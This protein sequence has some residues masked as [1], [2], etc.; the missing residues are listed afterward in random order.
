MGK[1]RTTLGTQL[2]IVL[3]I[4]LVMVVISALYMLLS[5]AVMQEDLL[6]V[7]IRGILFVVI[8]VAMGAYIYICRK[9]LI[10]FDKNEPQKIMTITKVLLV[11]IVLAFTADIV[12]LN[13]L[14][15]PRFA[16][17]GVAVT[18][19]IDYGKLALNIVLNIAIYAIMLYELKKDEKGNITTLDKWLWLAILAI[20]VY[21][22]APTFI[23]YCKSGGV[24]A[25]VG[26][27][28]V[29]I[30]VASQTLIACWITNPEKF[31]VDE[32]QGVVPPAVNEDRFV[33]Q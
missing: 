17:N 28:V 24:A 23:R 11:L 32:N 5:I 1:K 10:A 4:K 19:N 8:L 20:Y 9:Y 18:I 29:L 13:V 14:K 7:D 30:Y 2:H 15:S 12:Y 26:M 3:M 22:L 31:Y 27:S 33:N 21:F 6:P 16:Q 25:I